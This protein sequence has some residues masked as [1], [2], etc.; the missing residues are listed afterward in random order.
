MARGNEFAVPVVKEYAVRS[1]VIIHN[2]PSG[3]P[4][5]SKEDIQITKRLKESG[6]IIG[7]QLLDHII[8]GLEGYVSLKERGD[9]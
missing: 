1:D 9:I 2:H 6:N 4:E 3:N 5:P 7:I 8:V